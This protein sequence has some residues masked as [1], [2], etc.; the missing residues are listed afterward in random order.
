MKAEFISGEVVV[1]SPAKAKHLRATGRLFMLLKAHVDRHQLGEVFSEKALVALTRNDYEPDIAFFAAGKAEFSENRTVFPVPNF[2]AEVLSDLTADRDRGVKFD[3]YA[4]HGVA[5]YWIID[6]D[7]RAVEQYVLRGGAASYHLT[8]K[9]VN[10]QISSTVVK[11]LTIPVAAVFDDEAAGE[12][13]K[14]LLG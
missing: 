9:V 10:G 2:I 7:E 6:C 4:Q 5:E 12:A 13:L 14:A 3:D 11:N 8:Q 1:H